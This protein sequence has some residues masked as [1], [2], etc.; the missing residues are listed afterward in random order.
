[1]TDTPGQSIHTIIEAERLAALPA[2]SM[3]NLF[4]RYARGQQR[5]TLTAGHQRILRGLIGN[6]FCDN[7]CGMVLSRISNRL[8]LSRFEVDA[9]EASA[10]AG[11]A[12]E[13][14]LRQLWTFNH[15]PTLAEAVHFSALRDGN[16]A[17]ALNWRDDGRVSL[18][19]ERW[20][21]GSDG[22][23]VAYDEQGRTR[24][25]VKDWQA[26]EGLRR[27][28]WWPDRI[29]RYLAAGNGW[30]PYRLPGDG[31]TWPMPWLDRA[32]QP[33]GVPVVHFVAA[34]QPHDS[35]T[36]TTTTTKTPDSSYGLSRLDGGVLGLQDEINDV[37]RDFSAAGRFAGYQML[38][39]T[40]ITPRRDAQGREQPLI[41]EP[42][43]FFREENSQAAFGV[44]PAGSLTELERLLTVKLQAVSRATSVPQHLIAG[45]WPSGEALIR[46][47][48]PLVDQ[49]ES[50]A[51]SFGP[52]WASVAHKATRLAATFGTGQDLNTDL[53]I[54]AVY[55]PAERRDPFTRAEVAAKEAPYVSERQTLRTLGYAP[56][57]QDRIIAERQ[58]ERAAL[59][60]TV[61]AKLQITG[62]S[63]Q[64]ALRELGYSDAQIAAMAE[65]TERTGAGLGEALLTAFDRGQ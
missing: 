8:T 60:A 32:G 1:M 61:L 23:F 53:L 19:R 25:A 5:S 48:Q 35:D 10:A 36:E 31:D 40:G 43:A 29:A 28:I 49:V 11:A 44:L 15:M 26:R 22:V 62:F 63:P 38:Y 17:V 18:R 51:A 14:Y 41:V 39:G 6:L 30:Q 54:R 33:L 58:A 24:Y 37:Q 13:A 7:V 59:V 9:D 65:E 4:R 57:E 45:Q 55:A 56:A 46:A 42:G 34:T 12:V 50:L 16:Y 3:V 21:N 20:W 2:A 27:T 64:Q 47:E 52:A